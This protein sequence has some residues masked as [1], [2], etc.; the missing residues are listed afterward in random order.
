MNLKDTIKEENNKSL[1]ERAKTMIFIRHHLHEKLKVEYL[2][3]KDQLV[4]WKNLKKIY[5]H[6][7]F[8]TLSQAHYDWLHLR[9]QDFKS[10][11]EYNSIFFQ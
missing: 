1:Q 7:K 4:L 11:G 8:I 6:Q 9:L 3:I 10:I 5:D 2:T